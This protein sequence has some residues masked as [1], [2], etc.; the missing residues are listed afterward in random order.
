MEAQEAAQQPVEALEQQTATPPPPQ[1]ADEVHEGAAADAA[2][3]AHPLPAGTPASPAG[4][5][6]QAEEGE[7]PVRTV[8]RQLSR[9]SIPEP[10]EDE[11]VASPGSASARAGLEELPP[12]PSPN[13]KPVRRQGGAR[14]CYSLLLSSQIIQRCW[15]AIL[16]A[17]LQCSCV[18]KQVRLFWC[19]LTVP[20]C[21][22]AAPATDQRAL[23][24][25]LRATSGGLAH[26]G[27]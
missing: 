6:A 13:F 11:E 23:A 2:V 24:R 12:Q 14:A 5:P 7:D 25:A 17:W 20:P 27:C 18:P 26:G 19:L 16:V 10:E 9:L 22:S 1:D 8:S 15:S 21:P 3:P 4:S